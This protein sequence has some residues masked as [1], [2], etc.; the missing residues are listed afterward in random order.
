MCVC[1]CMHSESCF[2]LWPFHH[3]RANL[4]M[5]S[6]IITLR[7][8]AETS[9]FYVAR[10][11]WLIQYMELTTYLIPCTMYALAVKCISFVVLGLFLVPFFCL[12]FYNYTS[13]LLQGTLVY[14]LNST[15]VLFFASVR[16]V[17]RRIFGLKN[18]E[19]TGR[20]R[21]LHNEKIQKTYPAWDVRFVKTEEEKIY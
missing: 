20:W 9:W 17:L 4:W 3:Y 18:E 14:E 7:A 6:V 1:V 10:Y 13:F 12:S 8:R 11:S 2:T 16:Y 5:N 19:V 15:L 21:K